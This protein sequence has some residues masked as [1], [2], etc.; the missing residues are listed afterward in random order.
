[1]PTK[2]TWLRFH[3]DNGFHFDYFLAE[4]LHKTVGEIRA[5]SNREYMEWS[6][7]YSIKAQNAA[8]QKG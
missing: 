6:M 5:L 4:K 3:N 1:V 2:A 8:L 7:Y